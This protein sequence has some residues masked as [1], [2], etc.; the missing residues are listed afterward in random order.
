MSTPPYVYRYLNPRHE[1]ANSP[2]ASK[3][4]KELEKAQKKA[5]AKQWSAFINGLKTKGI[6]GLEIEDS[7]V[8]EY[9]NERDP[10]ASITRDELVSWLELNTLTVKELDLSVPQY[11]SWRN[12]KD[13]NS[14]YQESLYVLNS[15]RDDIEDRLLEIR[16]ELEELDFDLELLSENPMRALDLHKEKE[17][18]L[19]RVKTAVEVRFG[20][21]RGVTDK[22][23]GKQIANMIAHA[24]VTMRDDLYFIEEI[25]SDWA[26]RGRLQ[27]WGSVPKGP[28]VT[29]TEAWTG[30]IIRRQLQRAAMNESMKK[31]AWIRG[32]MRNGGGTGSNDQLDDFYMKIIPKIVDK[33]ISGTGE[34]TRLIPIT[35]NGSEVMVPGIEITEAVREKLRQQQPLYSRDIVKPWV[36]PMPTQE[37]VALDRE[38]KKAREMLGSIASIRLAQRVLDAATGEEVAG[39]Q[40]GRIIE[41]SLNA[42]NPAQALSHEVWHYADEHLISPEDQAA[43]HKAFENGSRL[44]YRVREVLVREGASSDA[45]AQ[46]DDPIEASAHGFALWMAGKLSLTHDEE[47]SKEGDGADGIDRSIG[48][49]FRKVEKAFISLSDWVRRLVGETEAMKATRTAAD[50]FS[51]LRDGRMREID[52]APIEQYLD[53]EHL[54]DNLFGSMRMRIR[55]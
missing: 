31:A 24:R 55:A 15:E 18:L 50:V 21:W 54:G 1:R 53:N 11:A 33:L 41:V 6:K 25:Q 49:I 36:K 34:K 43:V 26:Q 4:I 14:I 51:R 20:H 5:P 52:I 39:R 48:K 45:I 10:D 27:N 47:L 46:C 30:L 16:F 44:N 9:L 17:D 37:R 40:I 7:G 23:T 38:L 35:I 42:R 29:N 13:R 3:L 19:S 22:D 28:W 8:L 12:I 32:R 2:F